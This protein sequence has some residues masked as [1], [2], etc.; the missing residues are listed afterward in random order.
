[1]GSSELVLPLDFVLSV[2]DFLLLGFAD[3]SSNAR[4]LF[5]A[6]VSTS[7]QRSHQ[8]EAGILE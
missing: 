8:A 4:F 1:M 5:A 6:M 7:D 3:A 2:F